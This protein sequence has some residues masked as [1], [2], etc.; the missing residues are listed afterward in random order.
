MKP[1]STE[2]ERDCVSEWGHDFRPDYRRLGSLRDSLPGVPFVALTATATPRVRED[3]VRNL[4]MGSNAGRFVESFERSNLHFAVRQKTSMAEVAT[5]LKAAAARNRGQVPSTLI[6]ALTTREVDEI[7]TYLNQ[8]AV[9]NGRAGRYHAKMSPKERREAHAAFMRDDLDVLVA[10]VAYG[11]GIDKPNIRTILHWG[12]PASVEAYYQQA[13]RAGRD[14]A[15]SRCVLMWSAADAMTL[16][17]IKE[18]EGMS[19]EGRAAVQEAMA[20]MQAYCHST[21]CR[22]AQ[23]VNFFTAGTLPP[24]GPCRGGCD[25]CDRR[26]SGEVTSRD[27]ATEARLL[28]SAVEGLRNKYGMARSVHL[29]RGSRC[30]DL[31]P[32]MLEATHAVTGERLHGAGSGR[33]ESWWKGFGG[34]LN[35]EG[36][37][38]HHSVGDYQVV[39]VSDKGARWLRSGEP[40][41]RELPPALMEEEMR[42]HREAMARVRQQEER[43]QALTAEAEELEALR[44]ALRAERKRVADA[45]GHNAPDTLV[46]DL[47]LDSLAR[48]RPQ[49]PP[50]LRLVSGMGQAAVEA[51]GEPLM[52]VIRTFLDTAQHLGRGTATDWI[53]VARLRGRSDALAASSAAAPADPWVSGAAGGHADAMVDGG[54]VDMGEAGRLAARRL[55]NE[56]KGAAT[57][58]GSL[59]QG[60]MSAADIASKRA[61]PIAINTA[62][63]YVADCLAAGLAGDPA[64]LALEAGVDRDKALAVAAVIE[65][66]AAG[67]IGGVKR[68]LD[69]TGQRFEYGQIKVV[70]A[71]MATSALWFAAATGRA[72]ERSSPSPRSLF[73]EHPS[74]TANRQQPYQPYQQPSL[75]QEEERAAAAAA[76]AVAV[77]VAEEPTNWIDLRPMGRQ[78]PAAV[79][80]G[81]DATALSVGT[82]ATGVSSSPAGGAAGP[83]PPYHYCHHHSA[84]SAAVYLAAAESSPQNLLPYPSSSSM[85]PEMQRQPLSP[86]QPQSRQQ[87]QLQPP[88]PQQPQQ[89]LPQ[90]LQ[91]KQGFGNLSGAATPPSPP[92]L[93]GS[94][95][96]RPPLPSPSHSY[97][98]LVQRSPP[99]ATTGGLQTSPTAAGGGG[100]G[101]AATAATA[102]AASCNSGG[103]AGSCSQQV[104]VNDSPISLDGGI[105]AAP[106][107]VTAWT[108][109][110]AYV[111]GPGSGPAGRASASSGGSSHGNTS[112]TAASGGAAAASGGGGSAALQ[113]FTF[114]VTA[115]RVFPSYD[116]PDFPAALDEEAGSPFAAASLPLST[117]RPPPAAAAAAAAMAT[118]AGAAAAVPGGGFDS[119]VSAHDCQKRQDQKTP[120]PTAQDSGRSAGGGG[121]GGGG[122][123]SGG[124][125][126]PPVITGRK[127]TLPAL[128]GGSSAKRQQA[129][130]ATGAVPPN[131]RHL[132][133]VVTRDAVLSLVREH[134]PLTAV[135]LAD[136]LFYGAGNSSGSAGGTGGLAGDGSGCRD[137]NDD[138]A[139]A[140]ARAKLQGLMQELVEEF[141][142]VRQGAGSMQSVISMDD[143]STTFQV[144]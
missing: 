60:G 120:T 118:A 105:S 5:E 126:R 6:Y 1:V 7:A 9:L 107:A 33:S 93:P 73:P 106:T 140:A 134:G 44:A 67:G 66:H 116:T 94:I 144:L 26:A 4:S 46:S 112:R 11:M 10:S 52:K 137:S 142:V 139:T 70:A 76:A 27:V 96:G 3:I 72:P 82:P 138:A 117:P 135:V 128:C 31:Q 113:D 35:A 50:H 49:E 61:R 40:L 75:L 71:L 19:V 64:R 34:L 43:Q 97:P 84:T 101:G 29:L 119:C 132:E 62:L 81:N 59:W 104:I 85:S 38:Q 48:L 133:M 122:G 115:H 17:R 99:A 68:L 114:D 56:P 13:G 91:L 100:G 24:Q 136:R 55:L 83:Q 41:E 95:P 78:R 125:Y 25:M 123:A 103:T 8:P 121:G 53:A 108:S 129:T 69:S 51:F 32:W 102:A 57:D 22:H 141:E 58:A 63:G 45:L 28:L 42:A 87:Q 39:R 92:P 90:Q 124:C 127:R 77:A 36:L 109:S 23:L 15:D 20:K 89:L 130:V 18:A 47:T 74:T 37:L 110:C 131:A 143:N 86:L 65:S 79:A 30:K 21:S 16:S 88:P 12:C 111:R 14:G 80:A 54:G 98:S 2:R